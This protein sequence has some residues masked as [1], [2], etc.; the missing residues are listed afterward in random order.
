MKVKRRIIEIDQKLCDGCGMCVPACAE[1]AIEVVD[2]K[3]RLV[4]EKYCDGLGACIGQCP[5]GAIRV[6]EKEAE[7]FDEEAVAEYLRKRGK[8]AVFAS[9]NNWPVQIRLVSPNAS[10]L[11]DSE[12]VVI[13][14]CAVAVYDD[15]KNDLLKNRPFLIGC[16]KFDDADMY[17]DKFSEIF[18]NNNI[19][20]IVCV[21]MEVP[22]CSGLPMI[23]KKA[24]EI[25]DVQIPM[26][27][28]VV[29]VNRF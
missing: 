5:K 10:F 7:D 11:K 1:G 19:K 29:Y 20:K 18:K 22:C 6:V 28:V 24:M 8:R 21:M 26:E 23:L 13:S 4:S 14:D 12:L 25:A 3:A 16:P 15:L 2:G 9:P 27:E 17:V